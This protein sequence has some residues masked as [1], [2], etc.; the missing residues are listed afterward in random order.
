MPEEFPDPDGPD[1]LNEPPSF[2]P[3]DDE[4]AREPG[5][6]GDLIEVQIEGIYQ[7]ENA[8]NT[9]RYVMVTDGERKLPIMI[10]GFEAHAI[11]TTLENVRPDRPMTHDLLRNILERLDVGVDRVVID[12]LWNE[13]YYAKIYVKTDKEEFEVDARPSDAIAIAV[14]FAA[15]I[16]VA[17]GI[18]EMGQEGE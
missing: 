3:Y 4:P 7:S 15:P 12:D 14:R 6:M 13:I 16:F 18:L 8:A 10:G 2:F 9:S 5:A 17:E 11:S 1:N